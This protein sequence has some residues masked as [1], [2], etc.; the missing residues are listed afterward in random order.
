M[1]GTQNEQRNGRPDLSTIAPG[2]YASFS[3]TIRHSSSSPILSGWLRGPRDSSAIPR[4]P[5]RKNLS[6]HLYPVLALIPYSRHSARKFPPRSALQQNSIRWSIGSLF[7]Q[8]IQADISSTF[9]PPRVT[10]VL[11]LHHRARQSNL[12]WASQPVAFDQAPS[13]TSKN[14]S[15]KRETTGGDTR[16]T[17]WRP[18]P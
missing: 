1:G 15:R 18:A 13:H 16:L 14:L 4:T 8:G 3:P 6:C 7:F 2:R 17:I 5:S 11:N 10:Y 12:K 9:C